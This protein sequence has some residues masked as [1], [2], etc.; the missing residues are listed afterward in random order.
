M[1]SFRIFHEFLYLPAAVP[2]LKRMVSMAAQLNEE[3]NPPQ[4]FSFH[5]REIRV[6]DKTIF[7]PDH[8]PV[9]PDDQTLP[10]SCGSKG[11]FHHPPEAIIKEERRLPGF[12]FQR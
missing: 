2:V 4:T 12:F 6:I 5:Y 1:E 3:I 8:L 9:L 10:L 7:L 11:E